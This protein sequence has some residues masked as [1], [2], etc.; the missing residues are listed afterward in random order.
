MAI[1]YF[2]IEHGVQF[3]NKLYNL[4]IGYSALTN[5]TTGQMNIAMGYLALAFNTTRKL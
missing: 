3:A 2:N 1:Q 5:N 4:P